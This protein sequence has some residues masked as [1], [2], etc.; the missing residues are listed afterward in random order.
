MKGPILFIQLME[1]NPP[2]APRRV[3]ELTALPVIAHA[4]ASALASMKPE[5]TPVPAP[6]H[7]EA[8]TM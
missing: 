8:P 7:V 6:G 5:A 1:R 3:E 2:A 4:P